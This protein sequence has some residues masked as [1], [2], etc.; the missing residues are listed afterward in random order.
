MPS[1]ADVLNPQNSFIINLL[2][3]YKSIF[4][5]VDL[6]KGNMSDKIYYKAFFGI[7]KRV[8]DITNLI[9]ISSENN[10]K[11][12]ASPDEIS[13]LGIDIKDY[14]ADLIV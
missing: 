10:L 9:F 1:S 8:V 12:I 3:E 14:L 2:S 4:K 6:Y 11:P 5:N 7:E 13:K